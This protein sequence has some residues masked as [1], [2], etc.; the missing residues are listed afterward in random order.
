MLRPVVRDDWRLL[1]EWMGRGEMWLYHP[2]KRTNTMEETRAFVERAASGW[3][4]EP[5]LSR[6]WCA[7]AGNGRPVGLGNLS[8]LNP[9][10]RQAEFG[11]S[12]DQEHWGRGLGGEIARLLVDFGFGVL[13]MHRLVATCDPSNGRSIR[14]LRSLG[15]VHEGRLRD[16]VLG[17]DGWRDWDMF[18]MLE[19]E[20]CSTSDT[21]FRER[22][23]V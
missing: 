9:R 23:M 16:A 12:V 3:S 17:E 8:I 18:S 19:D 7:V 6:V 2:T 13:K 22:V 1:H 15:M 4:A 11:Y 14:L 10:W 20:W 5:V 21:S